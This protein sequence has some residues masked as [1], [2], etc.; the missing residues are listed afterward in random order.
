M[1]AINGG[2]TQPENNGKVDIGKSN[3]GS[4]TIVDIILKLFK[5]LIC[6]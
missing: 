2:F 3:G 5:G 6:W 4:A 1:E